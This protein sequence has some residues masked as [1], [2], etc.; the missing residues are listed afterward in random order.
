MRAPTSAG[1]PPSFGSVNA[2]SATPS[3]P[4]SLQFG[5]AAATSLN[6]WTSFSPVTPEPTKQSRLIFAAS[7]R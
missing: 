7:E 4:Y 3:G 1:M 5:Q 6:T 2:A